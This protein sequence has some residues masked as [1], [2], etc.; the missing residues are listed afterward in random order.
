MVLIHEIGVR[1]PV[2]SRVQKQ[3]PQGAIFV[4]DPRV[5]KLKL[6]YVGIEKLLP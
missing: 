4:R 5:K 1:F 2:G 3:A 6:L